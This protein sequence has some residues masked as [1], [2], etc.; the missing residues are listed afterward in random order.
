MIDELSRISLA[1]SNLSAD[2][3]RMQSLE[4]ENEDLK[5]KI[6]ENLEQKAYLEEKVKALTAEISKVT[7]QIGNLSQEKEG[8]AL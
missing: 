2:L 6:K 1:S 8:L 3:S 4:S 7:N 5:Q